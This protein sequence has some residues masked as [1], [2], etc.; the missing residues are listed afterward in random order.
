MLHSA[1][2]VSGPPSMV[3]HCHYKHD[4]AF[5]GVDQ[6]VWKLWKHPFAKTLGNLESRLGVLRQQGETYLAY[7]DETVAKSTQLGIEEY[8]AV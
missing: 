7:T 8:R 3:S 4:L 2:P 6:T 5:E 1:F